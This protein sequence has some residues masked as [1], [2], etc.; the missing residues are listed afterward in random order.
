MMAQEKQCRTCKYW[1]AV[2]GPAGRTLGH[3]VH[4]VYASDFRPLPISLGPRQEATNGVGSTS[5]LTPPTSKG[6][7]N[8]NGG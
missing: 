8:G 1:E 5:R 4:R 3:R 7:T 2:K 6:N